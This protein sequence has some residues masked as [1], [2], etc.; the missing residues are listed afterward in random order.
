MQESKLSEQ[1][2]NQAC[3]CSDSPDWEKIDSALEKYIGKKNQ[4]IAALRECQEIH[5]YLSEE[6][7]IHASA[8][9][10]IPLSE[11]FGVASFYSLFSFTP[12]GRNTIRLC[13]GT[14]CYVKGI[15]EIN[16]KIVAEYNLGET[17][18]SEDKRFGIEHVRCL[19]ACS[20]AP[21]MVVN[22]DTHGSM[23]ADKVNDI[24]SEYK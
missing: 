13:M 6:V 17:G 20:L 8:F 12:K 7:I 11:V 14:A 21:V 1:N 16:D 24:L 3:A 23:T 4:V 19:G 18:I 5:G 15:K 22:N 9:L 10:G 2:T